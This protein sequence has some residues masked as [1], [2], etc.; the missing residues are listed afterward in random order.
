MSDICMWA[1]FILAVA[2]IYLIA[3]AGW[4]LLIGGTVLC[5]AGGLD[6]RGRRP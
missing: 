2:G 5:V 3:G 4:A 1:G 6:A